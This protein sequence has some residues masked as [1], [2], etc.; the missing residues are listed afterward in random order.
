LKKGD[1]VKSKRW[2]WTGRVDGRSAGGN[3]KVWWLDGILK[4]RPAL[5]MASLLALAGPCAAPAYADALDE[6]IE[7]Q[8]ISEG[9]DVNAAPREDADDAV[10]SAIADQECREFAEAI[11][12]G[13]IDADE[14]CDR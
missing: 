14:W 10:D 4:D 9:D 5:V 6:F 2:G 1:I 8:R 7:E 11:G 12:L 3:I 13:P